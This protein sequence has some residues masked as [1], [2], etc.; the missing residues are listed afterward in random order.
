[1][2]DSQLIILS[3]YGS[4]RHYE[5]CRYLSDQM[6]FDYDLYSFGLWR[7]NLYEAARS[8]LTIVSSIL[9]QSTENVILSAE[10]FDWRIPIY[11]LL[12]TR[13]NLIY[14]TSWPFWSGERVPMDPV[15]ASHKDRWRSFL[16]SV[17]TVTVTKAAKEEL[18]TF[19]ANVTH[20]PHSVNTRQFRPSQAEDTDDKRVLYVGRIAKEKGI[21]VLL[22]ELENRRV[23]SDT[24]FRFVGEGP[25]ADRIERLSDFLPLEYIGYISDTGQLATE[26]ASADVLI[27]PSRRMGKWEELFG[28]VLIEAM[29]SGTPV[30][31][32]RCVGPSEIIDHGETGYLV[33]REATGEILDRVN[34][35]LS[36]PDRRRRMADNA[37]TVAVEEYSLDVVADQ[38]RS[39]LTKL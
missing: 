6:G 4:E 14:H 36:D 7:G 17:P 25:L 12:S 26:F 33:D 18:E 13:S 19:G 28:I 1:M 20:I 29:A 5:A 27:L 35:L 22:D 39:V 23:P 10:P 15:I 9:T 30:I 34:E 3:R 38:W 11:Q 2:Y 21:D 24:Q 37:R 31:S 8:S 32:T 16:S